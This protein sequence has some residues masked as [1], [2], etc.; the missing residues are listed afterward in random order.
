VKLADAPVPVKVTGA[1][2]PFV[3]GWW[4]LRRTPIRTN[5]ER[6]N[7]HLGKYSYGA[8]F[9]RCGNH[10]RIFRS[11]KNNRECTLQPL[12]RAAGG[13][14]DPHRH[15]LR[16]QLCNLCV[17]PAADKHFMNEKQLAREHAP[18]HEYLVATDAQTAARGRFGAVGIVAWAAV[19]I[20]F[21]IGLL[22]ALQKAAALL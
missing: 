15:G 7:Y 2:E 14:R 19:G 17:R 16:I 22:I 10:R 13:A 9:R 20:P 21:G 12:A 1:K 4:A 5:I 11:R 18:Q 3:F 6:K 8:H